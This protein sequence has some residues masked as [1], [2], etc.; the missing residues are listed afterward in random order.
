MTQLET[1]ISANENRFL[2]VFKALEAHMTVNGAL[3]VN[4]KV[5]I[6]GEEEAGGESI[7]HYV[8]TH[9]ERLQ[10]D[11]AFIC[12]THMPSRDIPALISG[13]RGIT[14]TEVEVHGAK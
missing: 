2:E 10:C 8:Q 3:P 9:P 5:L 1:Y 11:A 6:E 14:Y 12:D 13:L 7:A 4:V